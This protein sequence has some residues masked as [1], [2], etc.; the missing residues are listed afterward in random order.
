MKKKL[1]SVIL[2]LGMFGSLLSGCSGNTSGQ[3]TAVP[4]NTQGGQDSSEASGSETEAATEGGYTEVEK[5][6]LYTPFIGNNE[7]K[8]NV[9]EAINAI[10]RTEIGVELQWEQFDIGQWFQQYSLF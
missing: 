4:E 3:S 8:D 10:T 9:V 1:L 2:C 7:D 5:V 6:I